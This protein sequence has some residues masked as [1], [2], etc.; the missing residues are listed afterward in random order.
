MDW[1]QSWRL[2]RKAG[3]PGLGVR[4]R[5]CPA[6]TLGPE[7]S[8]AACPPRRKCGL[9][10]PSLVVDSDGFRRGSLTGKPLEIGSELHTEEVTLGRTLKRRAR[11]PFQDN[12][13][14][15]LH[16]ASDLSVEEPARGPETSCVA[17]AW[18][19]V[20]RRNRRA[21]DRDAGANSSTVLLMAKSCYFE[22]TNCH[23]AP[24]SGTFV[25]PCIP[26]RPNCRLPKDTS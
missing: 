11:D 23:F 26:F 24:K 6:M 12:V 13:L 14:D 25:A 2:D 15:R 7:T 8:H 21:R 16:S 1:Q 19:L 22:P 18:Q 20:P 9:S 3:T 5:P 10:T 4:S 17:I